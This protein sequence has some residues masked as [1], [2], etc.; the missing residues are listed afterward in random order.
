M[1]SL[2]SKA[3]LRAVDYDKIVRICQDFYQ[4]RGYKVELDSQIHPDVEWAPNV[5]AKK[6]HQR[7]SIEIRTIPTLPDYLKAAIK[8]AKRLVSSELIY[9]AAPADVADLPEFQTELKKLGV[10]LLRVRL[11]RLEEIFRQSVQ[12]QVLPR[13]V[14]LPSGKSVKPVQTLP[15]EKPYYAYLKIGEIAGRASKY[16][17]IIDAWCEDSTLKHLVR[18]PNSVRMRLVTSFEGKRATAEA[19]FLDAARIFKNEKTGFTAAKCPAKLLHDRYVITESETWQISQSIKDS[20]K[21]FGILCL[22]ADVPAKKEISNYFSSVWSK[23][24]VVI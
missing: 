18:S 6:K 14:K 20:G 16:I 8:D 13:F 9:V 1:S 22:I 15:A 5:Q 7:L 23:A 3:T 17:D 2:S 11:N 10:G 4:Q 21:K 19:P 24:T 12:K